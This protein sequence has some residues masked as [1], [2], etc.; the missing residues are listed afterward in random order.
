MSANRRI[1]ADLRQRRFAPLS[2]VGLCGTLDGQ[3]TGGN[4][5]EFE[6][7]QVGLEFDK[8]RGR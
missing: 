6:R 4:K 1:N 5:N 2:Q 7:S 8:P 3:R